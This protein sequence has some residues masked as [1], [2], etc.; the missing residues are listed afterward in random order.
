MTRT[1][2]LVSFAILLGT[3]LPLAHAD[4]GGSCHFHGKQA[5][6]ESVVTTCAKQR[7]DALVK[8]GRLESSWT[9]AAVISAEVVEG[10]K[11]KEWKVQ[12]TNPNAGDPAKRTLYLFFSHPGNFI[13]AN[14]TGQ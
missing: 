4:P 7:R 2:C 1:Q 12:M 14:F 9:A 6:S 10:K 3:A 8:A 13:A 11:G 5:A